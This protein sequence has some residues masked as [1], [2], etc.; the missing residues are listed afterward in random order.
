MDASRAGRLAIEEYDADGDGVVSGNELEKAPGLR[1]ALPRL[2][3]NSDKAVSAEEVAARIE[4]W[5]LMRT[6]LMSFSFLVTI[7]G[8]PLTEAE[9]TFEPE[10]FLGEEIKPAS[11]TTNR[12]G[13][14]GATIAKEDRPSPTYPPGMHLGLYKVRI[15]RIV[16]GKETIP[17]K[18]NA[19]TILGQELA[20]DVPEIANN[21][22]AYA[23]TTQ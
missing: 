13:G 7:D 5:Q 11:C 8:R 9:V 23:L 19:D 14:G 6:G 15:S 10:T 22:V 17:R 1:A 16:E 4:Q 12:F 18:Y 2:D 20:P 21:R 3:T